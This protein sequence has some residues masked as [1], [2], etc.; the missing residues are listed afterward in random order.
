VTTALLDLLSAPDAS[1][2]LVEPAS[3]DR[4]TYGELRAA[5]D[6]LARALAAAGVA[7]GDAVAMSL[8]NGPEI[9]T[10]FLGVV[11]AGAAA[12]PLNQA[13]TAEEFRSYLEDLQ[14]CA[15]LFLRGEASPARAACEAL[16]IRQLELAGERTSLLGLAGVTPAGS[17]PERDPEAIALLLHT[18]GT[19]SKPKGVPIRQRNLAASAR[20]VVATYGLTGDDA[21]HCVMPLFHVHGLVAST[22]ATL[23]SGGSVIAPRR[24][25]AST[26]WDD[27]AA[28]GAT[29]YSAVPTIHR[30]LLSRAEDGA[31]DHAGHG[32][33]FARSC[34]SALP[35]PLMDAFERRFELPLVEA[36]GMT[37]AAHQMASNPLPPGDRRAGSVGQPTGTEIAI[38]DDDWRPVATGG[39][40]E[41]C[42]RGPGVV[43]AY[44]ANPEATAASFRDGWFRTGDSGTLS[45]DG[46]LTLSGRLKELINRGGEKI[47]PHEV[48][49]ALLGHPDVLEAVAFALPDAKYGETVGA[50]VVART[51]IG[52]DALR[53]HC[54]E[55]LATFKVPVRIHVLDAIP[56]GPTGKVQRRLLAEQLP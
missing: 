38:L 28:H 14:P 27:S 23:A 45:P 44:R 50:A 37:E 11:A 15:M 52:E 42:V 53:A 41:V 24:F 17:A 43:D 51:A 8:P 21:S 30:I 40:G 10:A 2:A 25:S 7:A 48:E 31:S 5:A 6:R 26:F 3:G 56:K 29:W 13:Y 34:S 39:A 19:T 12:A 16:G 47:S 9:V 1:V 33:R 18:S 4:T 49:D 20:A 32:L 46:Y 36:Y 54:D 22:L 35:G 55:R